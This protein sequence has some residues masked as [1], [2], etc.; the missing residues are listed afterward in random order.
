MSGIEKST[1]E[2]EARWVRGTH[3]GRVGL[4]HDFRAGSLFLRMDDGGTTSG[5]PEDVVTEDG[6]TG[7]P[8]MARI[9][10]N[11]TLARLWRGTHRD[12]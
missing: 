4:I 6:L 2:I 5:S 8:L 1:R 11:P 9:M 12:A 10:P 3:A 7:S